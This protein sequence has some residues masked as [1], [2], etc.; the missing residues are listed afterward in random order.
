[1]E[2][3]LDNTKPGQVTGWIK[4]YREG[5]EPLT[6]TLALAGDCH[7]DLQGKRFRISNPN[8]TERF[9][10]DESGR[11]YVDGLDPVQTGQA[12]DITA[13]D[14]PR[15][16][17]GYPYIEWYS[18]SNGRMV[19][20]LERNQLEILEDTQ[21]IVQKLDPAQ[22]Y[23]NMARFMKDMVKTTGAQIGVVAGDVP[24]PDNTK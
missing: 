7:R 21:R 8:P 19:L 24:K 23:K 12:G 22:Q 10:A 6:V 13:G 14:P 16:Y 4:F 1:M 15:D 17:V 11:S 18:E 3:I 2:G 5:K 20:E 9:P